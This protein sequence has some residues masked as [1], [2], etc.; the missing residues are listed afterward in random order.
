M[1]T[2]YF[3][4]DDDELEKNINELKT[5]LKTYFPSN[6]MGYS[7]K[8]NSLPWIVTRMKAT[9]FYAEVVSDDEYNLVKELGY[10]PKEIIYNGPAK[11]EET[12]SEAIRN[13][14]IVNIETY[15]ELDWLEK[16]AEEETRVGLRL[17]I[18]LEELC[19]GEGPMGDNGGRF[20][21]PL[22]ELPKLIAR[23]QKKAI[24]AGLHVHST[25]RTRSLEVYKKITAELV[26]VIQKHSLNLEYVD[27]GGGFFGGVPDKPSFMEYMATIYQELQQVPNHQEL[28]LIVEPGSSMIASPI[29]FVTSVIDVKKTPQNIFVTTDGSR[30]NTDPLHQKDTYT[31]DISNES[32][33]PQEEVP[34]QIIV[35]FTCLETDQIIHLKKWP[36]LRTGQQITYYK[37]GAY[38]MGLNPLFI[39]Y[40][41]EVYVKIKN[42]YEKVRSKWTAHEYMQKAKVYQ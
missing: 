6:I 41:P 26:K 38:T 12:F 23:V 15:R 20:G 9:G 28:T 33:E 31:F 21:F 17:R 29:S 25:S 34:V 5:A 19:P 16:Y 18:N 8:T 7:V 10:S 14:S 27:I 4:I 37:V 11:S 22:A 32:S 39:R 24:L 2:P 42:R 13:Q 3:V 40:F 35:G 36:L 1:E 30:A